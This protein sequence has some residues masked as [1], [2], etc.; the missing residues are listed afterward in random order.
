MTTPPAKDYDPQAP[1]RLAL[2]V[3]AQ[4]ARDAR[5]RYWAKGRRK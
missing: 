5:G 2:N 3:I 1:D 4:A